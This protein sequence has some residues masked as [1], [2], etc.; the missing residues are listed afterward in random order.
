MR[1]LHHQETHNETFY[2]TYRH[3]PVRVASERVCL[4]PK[5]LDTGQ[6]RKLDPDI[7]V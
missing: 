2:F 5:G 6:Q 3:P 1:T 7:Q 4:S